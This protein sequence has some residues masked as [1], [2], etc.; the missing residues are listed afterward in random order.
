MPQ[1]LEEKATTFE[2]TSEQ[3]AEAVITEEDNSDI[4]EEISSGPFDYKRKYTDEY[5]EEYISNF[6]QNT[7]SFQIYLQRC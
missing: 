7:N 3:S 4:T 6:E 1:I 5:Y 2:L